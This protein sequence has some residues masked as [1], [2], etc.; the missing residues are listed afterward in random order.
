MP[1][2]NSSRSRFMVGSV[3][4]SLAPKSRSKKQQ[5][6]VPD[7]HR[8]A[9]TSQPVSED[10]ESEDI[11]VDS[12]FN[13][14]ILK[15]YNAQCSNKKPF[16]EPSV[17]QNFSQRVIMEFEEV[18]TDD[19]RPLA[20][21]PKSRPLTKRRQP[22]QRQ[23]KQAEE[24]PRCNKSILKADAKATL[25][26]SET[27]AARLEDMSLA[28]CGLCVNLGIEGEVVPRL[29]PESQSQL[30]TPRAV[31]QSSFM[32]T[33]RLTLSLNT[34]PTIE[35]LLTPA[36][37]TVRA[38]SDKV[39]ITPSPP[40]LSVSRVGP[41]RIQP[42]AYRAIHDSKLLSPVRFTSTA[43]PRGQKAISGVGLEDINPKMFLSELREQARPWQEEDLEKAEVESILSDTESLMDP[44]LH[45]PRVFRMTN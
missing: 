10:T 29:E 41:P 5:S 7:V 40:I 14:S 45:N 27:L 32:E 6:Y 15:R 20:R 34:P 12:Q 11:H 35:D 44:F 18:D 31:N 37:L 9:E 13:R 2:V 23:P 3:L 4:Q 21:F 16:R 1:Q 19:E 42:G 28:S 30:A 38:L 17:S 33:P 25:T 8:I 39:H 26:R 43:P 36:G 24:L 22:K